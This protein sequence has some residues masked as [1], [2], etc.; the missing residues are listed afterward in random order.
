MPAMKP[1]FSDAQNAADIVRDAGGRVVGRTR[2]QKM[3]YLLE[4]SGLGAGF[5]FGYRYYGPFSE[6]L[7][8]AVS[9][10]QYSELLA[11]EEHP[12]SWGGAYSVFKVIRS[13]S[14]SIK[15]DARTQILG[16]GVKANPVSLE[17]AATA[18]YL[19]L[20]GNRDPW[21]ETRRLKPEKAEKHLEDA[22]R[23]YAELR[24]VNTPKA[25]PPI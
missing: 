8:N 10:A 12:T 25:L 14:A 2:L 7:A 19:A 9:E 16:I 24:Q 5:D 6:D 20:E 13:G 23:L 21:S 4:I 17:L 15:R 3:A 1:Q 18:A 22:K 11:E